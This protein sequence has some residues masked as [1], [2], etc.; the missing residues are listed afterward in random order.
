MVLGRKLPEALRGAE[1]PPTTREAAVWIMGREGL[2]YPDPREY[3]RFENRV[4]AT[5]DGLR[6]RGLVERVGESRRVVRWRLADK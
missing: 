2:H 6:A 1:M 5:L 4:W 3:R